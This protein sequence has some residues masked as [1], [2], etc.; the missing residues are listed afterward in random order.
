MVEIAICQPRPATF[1]TT[2]ITQ[3]LPQYSMA[4]D[5]K[6]IWKK[7]E[8]TTRATIETLEIIIDAYYFYVRDS[9]ECL[10]A[11]VLMCLVNVCLLAILGVLFSLTWNFFHCR[12]LLPMSSLWENAMWHRFFPGE[13]R[14]VFEI[15]ILRTADNTLVTW[16]K[17][18]GPVVQKGDQCYSWFETLARRCGLYN[19]ILIVCLFQKY[20]NKN[21]HV[22]TDD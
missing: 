3:F 15:V 9:T 19:I 21:I 13:M 12:R 17:T 14:W 10:Q 4:C 2:C 20:L 1:A 11:E 7:I 18:Q 8:G 6:T 22:S 16:V 5:V